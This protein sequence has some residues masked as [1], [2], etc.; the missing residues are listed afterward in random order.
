[1]S[2]IFGNKFKISLFGE[3]HGTAIGAVLDGLPPGMSLDMEFIENELKR[4]RPG[5]SM[6]STAR[7][8]EDRFE[9]LSGYFRGKTTGSPLCAVIFNK[10]MNSADY[11]GKERFPRPGHADYTGYIKNRGFNDFRGGGHFSGRLTAPLVFAGAVA[12]QVLLQRGIVIGSHIKRIENVSDDSFDPVNIN[13]ELLDDL[14]ICTLPVIDKNVEEK[15]REC[16]LRAK[17]EKDSVGGIIETAVINLPVGIGA[18]FFDSMESRLAHA[19]FSIPAIKGVE[20]GEGF[21]ITGMRGSK[22]NDEFI[23][24]KGRVK[25]STNHNGGILGGITNGMPL[26]FRV[27]V[28]PTPSIGKLQRTADIISGQEVTITTEGR[29][30]PCIVPRAVPVVEAAAAAVIMDLL[31]EREGESGEIR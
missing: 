26:L 18:P 30:D 13:K 12:K 27:A 6:L 20:F 14:S 4:R 25:T 16:I 21:N 3:S 17:D 5:I 9:I 8:E 15:M 19:L 29:H 24:Q 28:K 31:T 11:A 10:D 23:F 7:R 22:A 1:M 2:S